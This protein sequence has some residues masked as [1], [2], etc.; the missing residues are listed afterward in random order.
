MTCDKCIHYDVCNQKIEMMRSYNN[1]SLDIPCTDFKDKSYFIELPCIPGDRIYA[2]FEDSFVRPVRIVDI[3]ITEDD[4]L[5][6]TPEYGK[7]KK[8][9]SYDLGQR[10][11]DGIFLT[12]KEAERALKE[13]KNN[14][15]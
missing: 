4:V 1:L 2:I 14:E 10:F 11:N 9:T 13:L 5:F 7:D 6:F 3:Q 8:P 15:T 12:R